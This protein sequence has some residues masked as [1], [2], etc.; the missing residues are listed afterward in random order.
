MRLPFPHWTVLAAFAAALVSF[1]IQYVT[2]FY[3]DMDFPRGM[4]ADAAAAFGLLWIVLTVISVRR[5][6]RQGL[7]PLLA[8]P[9]AFLTPIMMTLIVVACVVNFPKGCP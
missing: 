9:F 5:Y 1:T 2:M 6:G 4:K 7:W 3:V 8:A